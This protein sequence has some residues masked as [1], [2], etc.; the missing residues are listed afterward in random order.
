MS[1]VS[2]DFLE[3]KNHIITYSLNLGICNEI[4]K[5]FSYIQLV[6][7]LKKKQQTGIIIAKL[8]LLVN[9]PKKCRVLTAIMRNVGFYLQIQ[10]VDLEFVNRPFY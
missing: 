3:R 7:T 5:L 10:Y 8:V 9:D 2:A 6:F 1:H 4:C